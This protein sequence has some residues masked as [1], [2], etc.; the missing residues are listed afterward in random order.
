MT[1]EP[2]E[3]PQQPQWPVNQPPTP[4][5]APTPGAPY[6][7][8]HY[9]R[10]AKRRSAGKILLSV[11][12]GIVGLCLIGG[13]VTAIASAGDD[14]QPAGSAGDITTTTAAPAASTTAAAVAKPPEKPTTAAAQDKPALTVSQEQ[15]L[16]KA[17]DY[18][19]FSAFSRAG[20]IKQ[21]KFEG[22]A[23]ADATYAADNVGANWT[24]Q[25]DRKAKEYLDSGQS[26]S[27]AGL[28]K[29]LKFEGFS[30]AQA[31]HGASAVGL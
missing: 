11:I 4:T 2:S 20:L 15:A 8:G 5:S 30:D 29:Q 28:I 10:P 31:K 26:F 17:E 14:G 16:A 1:N 19:A 23:A 24:Q 21:L 3:Y 12:G 13:I 22:F 6:A 9:G 18:L 25:A 7:P 27:R